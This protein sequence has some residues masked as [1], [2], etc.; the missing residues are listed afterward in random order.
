VCR[1]GKDI[2]VADPDGR[3]TGSSPKRSL[4]AGQAKSYGT[5]GRRE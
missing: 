2:Q 5:A 1:R 3:P 4:G